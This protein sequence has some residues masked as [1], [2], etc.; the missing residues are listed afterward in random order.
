MS[1]LA[2]APIVGKR[3]ECSGFLH[4]RRVMSYIVWLAG[5]L[6]ILPAI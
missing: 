2:L 5:V 4:N 1:C 6:K 3:A